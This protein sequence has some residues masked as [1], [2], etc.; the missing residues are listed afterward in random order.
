MSLN[1]A[2]VRGSRKEKRN[3][4]RRE[5]INSTDAFFLLLPNIGYGLCRGRGERERERE[6][7]EEGGVD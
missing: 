4:L 1:Y 2:D 5:S 6:R 3:A 7:R